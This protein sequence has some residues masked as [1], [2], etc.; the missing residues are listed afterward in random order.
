MTLRKVK[1]T[2]SQFWGCSKFPRCRGTRNY[3]DPA[4]RANFQIKPVT[5]S[6][7]QSAIWRYIEE[8]DGHL[9]VQALA[10][11][12][13]SFT[14][15]HAMNR[16]IM[17]HPELD[18]IYLAFSR[19]IVKE[20][21]NRGDVHPDA[22]MLTLNA[23]GN[24]IIHDN[25]RGLPEKVS[26]DKLAD[27]IVELWGRT[28]NGEIDKSL[29]N[30]VEKLANLA[31]GYLVDGT[32][33]DE[34]I[35]LAARHD[36]ELDS[37][38]S[39]MALQM[40]PQ[41]LQIDRER[42]GVFSYN[43]QIWWPVVMGLPCKQYDIIFIDEAQDLNTCQ[44][45]LVLKLLRPGGRIVVVGDDNQAI[46]GF[47]GSDVDSI[48]NLAKLLE[49]TG[50]VVDT[51]PLTVTRR[52]PKAV[53]E[54]ARQWV[55][56]LQALPD[57]PEGEV[58][59][60]DTREALRQYKPGDMVLCRCNAP[61]TG[62]AYRLIKAGVKAIIRGRDIGKSLESIINKRRAKSINDLVQKLE[63]WKADEMAKWE[64]TRNGDQICARIQ[65]QYD[66]I[67][68]LCEDCQNITELLGRIKS[69]F[70]NFEADGQPRNAV[71][72]SSIHR[73]KGLEADNVFWLLPDIRIKCRQQWQKVQEKHLLYVAATRAKRRLVLVYQASN[74]NE[75]AA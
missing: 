61:L 40:V 73:A 58:S 68:T 57:A 70:A 19:E 27:I 59:R 17:D 4:A 43:D 66:C 34:L 48:N 53:V 31:M 20:F 15:C 33:R 52:C 51:L 64:N 13:K 36:V 7:E 46:F 23:I 1:A 63:K 10:G 6:P 42:T 35:E 2:G 38:I 45:K 26:E 14:C 3:V 72:L 24:Q 8:N 54:Y 22:S 28:N 67:V 9:I 47:R 29:L 5:G 21:R 50:K 25:I 65:D 12:G 39:E 41:V 18:C 32:N 11:T 55:P 56:G 75:A 62:V 37:D 30:A 71:V 69:I 74:E 49:A 16:L 44:H 60:T